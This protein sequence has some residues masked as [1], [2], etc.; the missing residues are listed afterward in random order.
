MAPTDPPPKK[1]W[2]PWWRRQQQQQQQ[3]QSTNSEMTPT[4]AACI[5]N[6]RHSDDMSFAEIGEWAKV[7]EKAA[8][9]VGARAEAFCRERHG[10]REWTS[11]EMIEMCEIEDE[12][13]KRKEREAAER[14][15]ASGFSASES[16][17]NCSAHFVKDF[18]QREYLLPISTSMLS[19]IHRVFDQRIVF[20]IIL[21]N[22]LTLPS[23]PVLQRSLQSSPLRPLQTPVARRN[24]KCS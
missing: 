22:L 14:R 7:S 8:R 11:R 9:E 17:R 3:E 1:K 12:E 2:Q 16:L 18:K 4:K 5:I 19:S 6:L 21:S 13:L 10:E 24:R 15:S 20:P 23:S